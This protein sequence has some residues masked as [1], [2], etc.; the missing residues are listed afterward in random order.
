ML[1]G[2]RLVVIWVQFMMLVNMIDIQL[3]LL[4]M[5]IF[6]LFLRCVVMGVGKML[7]SSWLEWCC[8]WIS[9]RC[10]LVRWV[11]IFFF[12]RI[13]QC[14]RMKMIEVMVMKLSVKKL[15]LV[16][17]GML[18][19]FVVIGI[20]LL[21]LDSSVR[22]IQVRNQLI[23]LCVL[24]QII[25][26]KGLSSFQ[27]MMLLELM[28]L[29]M[30]YCMMKGV[31]RNRLSWVVWKCGKLLVW[32]QFIRLLVS[33]N[34]QM[35]G[36]VLDRLELNVLQM[37]SYRVEVMLM[38]LVVNISSVLLSCFCLL[39]LGVML[40]CLSCVRK[41]LGMVVFMV[42]VFIVVFDCKY[43]IVNEFGSVDVVG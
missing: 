40:V 6:L 22:L 3:K 32:M 5:I 26:L 21:R 31:S 28:K 34:W 38:R 18:S 4:V 16:C 30:V 8:L 13:E 2:G 25:V 11:L 7:S 24:R 43:V 41:L 33:S 20:R 12:L 29:L 42:V 37:I 14:S 27:R 1:W 23:D 35:K 17:M 10:V 39:L 36:R 15:M 9:C 19:L